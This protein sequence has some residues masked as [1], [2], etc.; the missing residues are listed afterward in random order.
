MSADLSTW[1][2]LVWQAL[3]ENDP[4]RKDVLLKRAQSLLE[5]QR[6]RTMRRA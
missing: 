2:N 1:L 4:T 3:A 6:N 5:G